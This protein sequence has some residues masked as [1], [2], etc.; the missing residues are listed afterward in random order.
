MLA[1]AAPPPETWN[2]LVTDPAVALGSTATVSRS[3]R[4]S[5]MGTTSVSAHVTTDAP[6]TAEPLGPV[7]EKLAPALAFAVETAVTSAGSVATRSS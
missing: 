5:C 2:E 3:V 1:D 7:H 6:A 4:K